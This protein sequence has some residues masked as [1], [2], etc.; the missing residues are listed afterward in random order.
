LIDGAARGEAAVLR[1]APA[2]V[3]EREPEVGDFLSVRG[4]IVPLAPFEDYQHRRGAHAA[5]AVSALHPTGARRGGLAGGLD[6]VRRRAEAGLSV[7]LPA[8]EAALSLGMVLGQ[9]ERLDDGVRQDFQRSGL[10]HL[11]AVSGQ[12]VMLLALLVLGL[13]AMVGLGLRA[14]LLTA[15]ALVALYVPLTGAG[16]S[17]QR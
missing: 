6:M 17:I 12:N 5:L 4:R 2:L 1:V 7:G 14:R 11:L 8:P 10:A 3:P 15:L 16:P 9:D 13:A